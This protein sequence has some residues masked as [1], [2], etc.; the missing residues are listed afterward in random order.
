MNGFHLLGGGL[1][2]SMVVAYVV[3]VLAG[4]ASVLRTAQPRGM[5]LVWFCL[6]WVAPFLGSLAWFAF[7]KPYA[8]RND[9]A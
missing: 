3:V 5:K 6:V 8:L 9:P 7:G 1:L 4:L 2:I